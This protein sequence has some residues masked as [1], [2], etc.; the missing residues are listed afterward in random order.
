MHVTD[1][2]ASIGMDH[3]R[4]V[5]GV[6]WLQAALKH[7]PVL[8]VEEF[9]FA[10]ILTAL[11]LLRDA[12]KRHP[13]GLVGIGDDYVRLAVAILQAPIENHDTEPSP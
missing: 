2:L 7:A 1:H 9:A 13:H 11:G 10:L 3:T 4:V 8:P 12:A 6:E 5:R